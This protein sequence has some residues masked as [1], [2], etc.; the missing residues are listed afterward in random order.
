MELT[1]NKDGKLY[2]EEK[3]IDDTVASSD[4]NLTNNEDLSFVNNLTL[5]LTSLQVS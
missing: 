1:S 3:T 5:G 2:G 4:G